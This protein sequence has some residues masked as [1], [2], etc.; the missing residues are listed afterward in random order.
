MDQRAESECLNVRR[1]AIRENLNGALDAAG[2]FTFTNLG[3]M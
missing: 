1:T 3:E 2:G